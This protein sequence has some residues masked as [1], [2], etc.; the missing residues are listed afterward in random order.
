MCACVPFL[1]ET[2]SMRE[3]IQPILIKL[4][5][6]FFFFLRDFVRATNSSHIFALGEFRFTAFIN[7]IS[8][9]DALLSV[10]V[11]LSEDFRVTWD[12]L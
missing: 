2:T 11:V 12:S 5:C 7:L 3:G 9:R 8:D 10:H 4:L 1:G 6:F